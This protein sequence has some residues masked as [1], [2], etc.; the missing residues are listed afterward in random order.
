MLTAEEREF[1]E[2]QASMGPLTYRPA[3]PRKSQAAAPTG[4]R[5]DVKG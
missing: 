1:F 5:I 4:Q 3:S 2:A